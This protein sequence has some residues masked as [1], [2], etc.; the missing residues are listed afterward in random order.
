M[1]KIISNVG[2][3]LNGIITALLTPVVSTILQNYA[4][5]INVTLGNMETTDAN[6]KTNGQEPSSKIDGARKL[7]R[8]DAN[9][10]N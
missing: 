4:S 1:S 9:Q 3:W 5:Q 2:K 6:R 8:L 10:R 7:I